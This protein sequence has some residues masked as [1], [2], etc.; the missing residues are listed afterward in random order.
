MIKTKL[1]NF[2]VPLPEVLYNRLRKEAEQSSEPSTEIARH[3]IEEYLEKRRKDALYSAIRD[4][5]RRHAGTAVDLDN[6]LE[7]ASSE[8]LATEEGEAT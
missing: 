4:Y 8:F 6:D 3:A 1:Y 2:H 5:A 7:A